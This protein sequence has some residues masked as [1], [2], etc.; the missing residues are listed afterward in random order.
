[1]GD[2]QIPLSCGFD[3]FPNALAPLTAQLSEFFTG[4]SIF[5]E[6]LSQGSKMLFVVSPTSD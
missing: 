3:Y 6:C 5:G 4:D 1:M 2:D